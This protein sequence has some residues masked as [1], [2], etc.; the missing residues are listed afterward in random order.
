MAITIVGT[1]EASA[2]NDND[3]TIT[4]PGGMMENDLVVVFGG[5]SAVADSDPPGPTTAG[6]TSISDTTTTFKGNA[7]YKFMSGSPDAT[8]ACQGGSFSTFAGHMGSSYVATVYRGV[9]V[10]TPLD[11]AAT[12]ALNNSTNP[13]PSSITT[14]TDNALVIACAGSGVNDTSITAPT[15]YSNQVDINADDL[16]D[17][18]VG[19]AGKII[20]SHGAEDPASWTNWSSGSWGCITI[21]LRD[22]E[23]TGSGAGAKSYGF[24]IG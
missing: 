3:V 8:V 20:T 15:G 2:I 10:T 1:A 4:L 13:N 23:S 16:I 9:D 24:V 6:Y 22:I 14:T 5:F 19:M 11:T 21:A 18:T 17:S 7:S 12:T